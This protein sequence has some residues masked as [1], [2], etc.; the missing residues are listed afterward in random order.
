MCS[1]KFLNNKKLEQILQK[2]KHY[3]EYLRAVS[4][5]ASS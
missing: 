3:N 2:A 5:Q 4:K 1:T